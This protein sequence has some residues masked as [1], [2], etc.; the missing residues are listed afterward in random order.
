MGFWKKLGIWNMFTG[1]TPEAKAIGAIV[2]LDEYEKEQETKQGQLYHEETYNWSECNNCHNIVQEGMKECPSCGKKFKQTLN[3]NENKNTKVNIYD[4]QGNIIN[5]SNLKIQKKKFYKAGVNIDPGDYFFFS[6][7]NKGMYIIGAGQINGPSDM[8]DVLNKDDYC[9][10]GTFVRLLVSDSLFIDNGFLINANLISKVEYINPNGLYS[11]RIGIDIPE[12]KYQFKLYDENC[13]AHFVCYQE[14]Q[15]GRA[16]EQEKAEGWFDS[17]TELDINEGF[18]MYLDRNIYIDKIVDFEN[19]EKKD[20]NTLFSNIIENNN[21]DF[22]NMK[23]FPDSQYLIGKDI[24]E[25]NYLFY[26]PTGE[27]YFS[28]TTDSNGDDIITNGSGIMSCFINLT[29]NLFVYINNGYLISTSSFDSLNYKNIEGETIY[30]IGLDKPEG[31]YKIKTKRNINGYFCIYDGPF[32][33]KTEIISNGNFKGTRYV[34]VRNGNYFQ[35]DENISIIERT[36]FP[37]ENNIKEKE[38]ENNFEIQKKENID[39]YAINNTELTKFDGIKKIKFDD[40]SIADIEYQPFLALNA[41]DDVKQKLLDYYRTF[42]LNRIIDNKKIIDINIYPYNDHNLIMFDQKCNNCNRVLRNTALE[43]ATCKCTSIRRKDWNIV[44]HLNKYSTF[45]EFLKF[46]TFTPNER[47]FILDPNKQ[48]EQDNVFK[49]TYNQYLLHPKRI[50]L[51]DS[52]E[53]CLNCGMKKDKKERCHICNTLIYNNKDIRKEIV[54]KRAYEKEDID[55]SWECGIIPYC[56]YYSYNYV[57]YSYVDTVVELNLKY[58]YLEN[59]KLNRMGSYNIKYIDNNSMISDYLFYIKNIGLLRFENVYKEFRNNIFNPIIYYYVNNQYINPEIQLLKTT[60]MIKLKFIYFSKNEDTDAFSLN[61]YEND[62]LILKIEQIKGVL[63]YIPSKYILLEMKNN[64]KQ[65]FDIYSNELIETNYD[66]TLETHNFS[67][68]NT[69]ITY[70]FEKK[71]FNENIEKQ[72]RK[73]TKVDNEKYKLVYINKGFYKDNL[74]LFK[75]LKD[76]FE[77]ELL[78]NEFDNDKSENYVAKIDRSN[79]K[80]ISFVEYILTKSKAYEIKESLNYQVYGIPLKY[81]L[82]TLISNLKNKEEICKLIENDILII[83]N[84]EKRKNLL[85][86]IN[87]CFFTEEKEKMH[88]CQKLMKKY[89]TDAQGLIVIMLYKYGEELTFHLPSAEN[90]HYEISDYST[91]IQNNCDTEENK[92]LFNKI[93]SELDVEQI[94]WKSEFTMFKL[95]KNYFPDAVYQYRFKELGLQ[96]LDVY[97]PSIKIGFEYQGQQHYEPVEVFGGLEHFEK[98]KEN[99]NLKKEICKNNDIALIE[100]KYT[101]SINKLVLDQKLNDYRDKISNVYK[102]ND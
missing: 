40:G 81:I 58:Y 52:E 87:G 71:Y 82:H 35:I 53:A 91:A 44:Q 57:D 24:D 12:G 17:K 13:A 10:T 90:L 42:F 5:K 65:Y 97:I 39:G 63:K 68:L 69:N 1:K 73:F 36:D 59:N 7:D 100:W 64:K 84:K 83:E 93:Y 66:G 60:E 45:E 28:I 75:Y 20:N 46:E 50:K 94:K 86:Y 38:L 80:A 26:S 62:D 22:N 43:K 16:N 78:E 89:D 34:E 41:G 72:L 3:S 23:V 6:P 56:C 99:D 18:V 33:T 49:G 102:F 79:K 77:L 15:T 4:K 19:C 92:I 54:S 11:Y 98:Q 76:N 55:N 37:S 61:V 74:I 9:V 47:Y 27:G 21:H 88:I 48:I 51:D 32:D 96:S 2:A 67:D 29:R 95:L 8:Y 31:I 101:E 70:D 85:D 14:P 25:G 30:R